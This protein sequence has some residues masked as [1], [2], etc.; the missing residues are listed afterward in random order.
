LVAG[1]IFSLSFTFQR[2]L[3][4]ELA[5]LS[6]DRWF[7]MGSVVDYVMYVVVGLVMIWAARAILKGYH[8]HLFGSHRDH[9]KNPFSANGEPRDPRRWMP[10]VHG[11]VAGWG[12]G[13]FAIMIYTILAPSMPSAAWAWVPG[14]MFGLGT[15]VIQAAAGG[16]FGWISKRRGLTPEAIR[17]VAL[18]TAGRTMGWGGVVFVGGG[19]FGLLFPKIAGLS[20]ATGIHVHNLDRL[21]LGLVLVMGTVLGIGVTTLVQQTR[22]WSR[23]P[24]DGVVVEH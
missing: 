13:A 6:L 9:R 14:A 15:T 16:L 4:S 12:F 5:Y 21:G 18:N 8:W 17:K 24:G 23:H 3:A 22:Y 11:F 2:A 20:L 1:L 19:L 10:A 7:T